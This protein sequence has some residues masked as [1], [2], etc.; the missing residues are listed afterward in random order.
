ISGFTGSGTTVVR[1]ASPT[2]ATP[3]LTNPV[4]VTTG[5]I[6]DA[7]GD[8]YLTFVEHATPANDFMITQGTTAAPCVLTAIG[9]VNAGMQITGSGTGTVEIIAPKIAATDWTNANHSHAAGNS[10]GQ[11]A[12]SDTTG[13]LA[14]TRGGTDLSSF[15]ANSI[16]YASGVN[17]WAER[18]AGSNDDV[19]TIVAGVPT[20]QAPAGGSTHELLS[21]THTDTTTATVVRGDLVVGQ[22]VSPKWERLAIGT[23]GQVLTNTGTDTL[24]GSTVRITQL[25][26]T[27]G[28]NLID[29]T[30]TT[31]AVNGLD[32]INEI[33]GQRPRIGTTGEADIGID[34]QNDQDENILRL[35][36]V[37]TGVTY[38]EIQNNITNNNP[39]LTV[40]GETNV[41]MDI[42]SA[43]TGNIRLIDGR[44]SDRLIASYVSVATAG[45]YMQ[46]QQGVVDGDTLIRSQTQ[47]ASTAAG[48]N[49]VP[50]GAGIV[51]IN[52]VEAVDISSGQTLTNKVID[53]SQLVDGSVALAKHADFK[54][55]SI[56]GK[57]TAGTGAP[58]NLDETDIPTEAAPTTGDWLLGWDAAGL[59]VKYDIGNLPA[60]GEIN[61]LSVI[62]TGIADN[63][64]ALGTGVNTA[65]Y[66]TVPTSQALQFNGT[67][68]V[69]AALADLSDVTGTTG[70]GSTVVFSTSPTLTTPIIV[71]TGSINDAGGDPY[72]EFVEATTPVNYFR[73]TQSTAAGNPA[74]LTAVGSANAGMILAGSGTGTVQLIAPEVASTDWTNANHSH[75]AGN[76]GGAIAIS[77]TTG[78]LAEGRGGTNQT[79][80][81]TGDILYASA[82][83]TLS[84]LAVG[85]NEDVLRVQGGIPN[86]VSPTRV[87][88][89]TLENPTATEDV[90]LWYTDVAVT[91]LNTRTVL[92]NGTA[93]PTVTWEIRYDADRSAV[94]TVLQT[95]VAT[96]STTTGDSDS[97]FTNPNIPAGRWVWL[98]TTAQGGTV[99]EFHISIQYDEQ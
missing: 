64:L 99:P 10:G 66:T 15:S 86:W 35:T 26:D 61:D 32:I 38:Y 24:W 78:T 92:N 50:T 97:T 44:G 91:I 16:L 1:D 25:L 81:A 23:A 57:D 54:E 12:I 7:G 73:I 8:P 37:A 41:G 96:T 68:F 94:G 48:I 43:G 46:I 29:L 14:G 17:T 2:I 42:Q 60:G 21:A 13:T 67:A 9:E 77:A 70:T 55:Y 19:L 33:T 27:N 6:T 93:T 76:S 80:Y 28:T 51:K 84:K 82:S 3:T 39:V 34:F 20:W 90:T 5:T 56:L 95:A 30:T 52:S 18:V 74:L 69:Q 40:A 72:V 89:L 47:G 49:L 59:L 11:I 31:S 58:L 71:T 87:K 63:Q 83:N 75:A 4:I 62:T 45:T 36:P 85:T 65:I 98:T 88:S 22:Q 79:T 53:G